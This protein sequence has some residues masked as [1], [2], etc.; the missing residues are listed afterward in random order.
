VNLIDFDFV[1]NF[2][3]LRLNE[4]KPVTHDKITVWPLLSRPKVEEPK[5]GLERLWKKPST[6]NKILHD[7]SL[8]WS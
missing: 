7:T 8:N 6:T 5:G 1:E 3:M 2:A 4:H